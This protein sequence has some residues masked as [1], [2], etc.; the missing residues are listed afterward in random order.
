[1]KQSHFIIFAL[2]GFL[3]LGCQDQLV[4]RDEAPLVEIATK[5]GADEYSVQTNERYVFPS[6]KDYKAWTDIVSLEERLASCEVPASTLRAMTTDALVRTVLNY[7]LNFIYSAYDNPLDAVDIIVKNSPLHQEL[8]SRSD[9]VKVLLQHFD[10]TF[11]DRSGRKSM[12][13]LMKYFLNTFW[14][15]VWIPDSIRKGTSRHSRR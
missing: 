3:M 15:T 5:A 7:P 14:P 4:L 2:L 11:I 10:Q 8:F 12:F 1:M 6:E 9:A 13:N